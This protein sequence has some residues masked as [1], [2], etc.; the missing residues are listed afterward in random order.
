[1]EEKIFTEEELEKYD[2]QNGKPA[3]VAIDGVVYDV[4][5]VSA[6]KGGVHHGNKAGQNFSEIIKKSP[7][8]KKVLD[9]LEK[10]GKLAD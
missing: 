6:W 10:V 3:Y 9:K 5:D 8:G 4:T 1:M 2:G 7:H